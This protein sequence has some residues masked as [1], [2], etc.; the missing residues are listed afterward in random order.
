MKIVTG[1]FTI[2]IVRLFPI[3]V[4]S[5]ILANCLQFPIPPPSPYNW[6]KIQHNGLWIMVWA[7]VEWDPNLEMNK[8]S[9]LRG[10]KLRQFMD[11]L[12]EL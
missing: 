10:E 12:T 7:K 6:I 9:I 5:V 3:F 2:L 1:I 8:L 4:C 11:L